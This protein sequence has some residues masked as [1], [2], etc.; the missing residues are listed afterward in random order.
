VSDALATCYPEFLLFECSICGTA[1]Y[2]RKGSFQVQVAEA[3]LAPLASDHLLPT[4]SCISG[5]YHT[6]LRRSTNAALFLC[7]VLTLDRCDGL[8]GGRH[9]GGDHLRSSVR[10]ALPLAGAGAVRRLPRHRGRGYAAAQPG[11]RPLVMLPR[12]DLRGRPA[13]WPPHQ[14]PIP[15]VDHSEIGLVGRLEGW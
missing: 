1:R 4:H 12:P 2:R 9:A 15:A 10:R 3:Q 14:R 7:Q 8:R 6:I 5:L 13:H 11:P